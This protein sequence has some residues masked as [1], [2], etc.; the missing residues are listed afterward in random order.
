MEWLGL[1]QVSRNEEQS[2]YMQKKRDFLDLFHGRGTSLHLVWRKTS[3]S[4]RQNLL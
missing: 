1:Q 4:Q 3:I 2:H